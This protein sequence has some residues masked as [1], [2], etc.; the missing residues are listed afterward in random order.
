MLAMAQSVGTPPAPYRHS[1]GQCWIASLTSQGNY[2]SATRRGPGRK[3]VKISKKICTGRSAKQRAG[4]HG[5]LPPALGSPLDPPSN[6][7][8]NAAAGFIPQSMA[9]E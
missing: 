9:P 2:S 6:D 7:L 4:D 5:R 8:I 3:Q 1:R